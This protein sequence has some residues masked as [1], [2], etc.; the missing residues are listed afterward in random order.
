M[1]ILLIEEKTNKE[2]DMCRAKT[3]SH[4]ILASLIVGLLLVTAN[5]SALGQAAKWIF[6]GKS[7]RAG[8][9][10][11]VETR[12]ENLVDVA[13]RAGNFDEYFGSLV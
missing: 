1:F 9:S 3:E 10:A 2:K 13:L 7:D 5:D 4:R 11:V 6:S 8:H 12:K